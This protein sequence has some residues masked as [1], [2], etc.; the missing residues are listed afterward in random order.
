M[1]VCDK[2]Q[3]GSISNVQAALAVRGF[4]Y[5]EKYFVSCFAVRDVFPQLFAVECVSLTKF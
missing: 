3:F 2:L 5:S 4:D 1:C